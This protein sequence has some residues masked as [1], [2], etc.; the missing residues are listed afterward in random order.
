MSR[1]GPGM[2]TRPGCWP[3]R[4][5]RPGTGRG[6]P[7]ACGPGCRHRPG[8]LAVRIA[9]AALLLAY[10]AAVAVAGARWLPRAA[11]PQ[12]APRA[13]IAAWLA[14]AL[15]AAACAAAA[16]LIL[17]IPCAHLITHPGTLDRKSTRLNS[18][19]PSISYAVFCLKKKKT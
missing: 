9:V 5:R 19:H 13:G 8:V 10:A 6:G 18:S 12:R 3:R 16:G 2:T 11:W 17:A 15:S 4:C 7:A 14:G 1:H